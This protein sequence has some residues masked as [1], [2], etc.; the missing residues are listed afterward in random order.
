[1]R[2]TAKLCFMSQPEKNLLNYNPNSAQPKHLE[3]VIPDDVPT[4][5][6][7]SDAELGA[8]GRLDPTGLRVR[9]VPDPQ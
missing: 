8:L 1:M 4:S 5:R 2:I 3:L 6:A 9:E 7:P